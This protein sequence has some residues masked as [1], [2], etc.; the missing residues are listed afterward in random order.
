MRACFLGQN[1]CALGYGVAMIQTYPAGDSEPLH[2]PSEAEAG[3]MLPPEEFPLE[4]MMVR[5]L[6]RQPGCMV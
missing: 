5:D 2:G 6:K 3:K 1:V 4:N